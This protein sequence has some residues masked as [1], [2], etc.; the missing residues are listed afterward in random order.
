MLA[1]FVALDDERALQLRG[2]LHIIISVDAQDILHHIAGT[3]HIDSVGR[4]LD[5]HF[6]SGLGEDF[7]LQRGANILN[8]VNG[9]LLTYQR[10]G[11][12]KRKLHFGVLDG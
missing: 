8:S 12:I 7:H 3:L 6:L 9:Y 4:N 5:H 11:V 10:L 1:V 2:N